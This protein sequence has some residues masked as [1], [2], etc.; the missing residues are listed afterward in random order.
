MNHK[1]TNEVGDGSSCSSFR[2]YSHSGENT[3]PW[4][5]LGKM[6]DLGEGRRYSSVVHSLLARAKVDHYAR[7]D[8][9]HYHHRTRHIAAAEEIRILHTA[10]EAAGHRSR[11]HIHHTVA[12]G[13]A[14]HKA[15]RAR[16]VEGARTASGSVGA[17]REAARSSVGAAGRAGAPTMSEEGWRWSGRR[18]IA[19]SFR[20]G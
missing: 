7:I 19:R 9:S 1:K 2:L 15:I 18:S 13:A 11:H 12:V 14:H 10:A 20:F 6:S 17:G 8:R 16:R 3:R 5:L 4:A